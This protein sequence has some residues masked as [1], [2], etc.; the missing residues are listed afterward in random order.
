MVVF[1]ARQTAPHHARETTFLR[2][3]IGRADDRASATTTCVVGRAIPARAAP[4]RRGLTRHDVVTRSLDDSSDMCHVRARHAEP[5]APALRSCLPT[6]ERM[7]GSAFDA[8]LSRVLN[9]AVRVDIQ[10]INTRSTE[11]E[12][13]RFYS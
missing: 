13:I 6:L 11:S 4:R 3:S 9:V 12:M 5:R 7:N 2:W 1:I 8:F 10:K